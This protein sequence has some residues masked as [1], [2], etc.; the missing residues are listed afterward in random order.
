MTTRETKHTPGPWQV[1]LFEYVQ[2]SK[3]PLLPKLHCQIL[4]N[5]NGGAFVTGSH[6]EADAR[7]IAASPKMFKVLEQVH[8]SV[9]EP[10]KWAQNVRFVLQDADGVERKPLTAL[11]ARARNYVRDAAPELLEALKGILDIGKRD[12]SNPKYDGYFETAKAAI[13]KAEGKV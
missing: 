4:M 10:D 11:E 3:V 6:F 12:M 2:R 9:F 1:G 13:A 8:D 7:L 5:G